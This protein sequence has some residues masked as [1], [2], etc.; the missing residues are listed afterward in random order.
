MLKQKALKKILVTTLTIVI[1]LMIYIV[2]GNSSSIDTL[3]VIPQ[4]EYKDTKIGYIYL[5]ND[6]DFLVKVNVLLNEEFDLED[7]AKEIINKLLSGNTNPKGLESIIPKGVSLIELDEDEG[8]LSINFSKELLKVEDSFQSKLIEAIAYSLFELDDIKKI[9]IYVEDKSIS[10][11]F[12][13]IPEI[14]TRNFGINKKYDIKSFKDVKKIVTYYIDEIDNNKYMVPVTSYINDDEE[15]IKIIIE[16]L[17]SNYIY[18]PNLISL[19]NSKTE[20]INYEI[21]DDIMLLNFNNS[22]FVEDGSILEEVVY[23]I[24]NSIFDTYD[25]N[26]VIF[27]VENKTIREISNGL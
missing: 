27:N 25:I 5:L 15:K 17:S 18:E 14:I 16:N 2:P 3:E 7:K 20:L 23:T 9:S 21:N 8:Y 4:I 10:E 19:L 24:S 22:I 12:K 26:K 13:N 11:Y 1:F 6:N